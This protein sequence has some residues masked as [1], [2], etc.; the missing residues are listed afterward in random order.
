MRPGSLGSNF[1]DR[2]SRECTS[3]ESRMLLTSD[4]AHTKHPPLALAPWGGATAEIEGGTTQKG[5]VAARMFGNGAREYMQKFGGS[6]ETLA[7]I[8]GSM[9][10]F[11]TYLHTIDCFLSCEEPSARLRKP[12]LPVPQAVDGRAGRTSA[13]GHGRT[14]TPHV[15][16]YKRRW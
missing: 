15:L 11:G 13:K 14:V 8:G 10:S 1:P 2:V 9:R 4:Q 6:Y 16:P 12:V 7:K 5:P 3:H